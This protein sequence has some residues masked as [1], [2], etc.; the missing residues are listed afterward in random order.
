MTAPHACWTRSSRSPDRSP[1]RS[2]GHENQADPIQTE[3]P[4]RARIENREAEGEG[5]E[6]GHSSSSIGYSTTDAR[7]ASLA[8]SDP[9][10]TIV[11][12]PPA[13]GGSRALVEPCSGRAIGARLTE[14]TADSVDGR[15]SF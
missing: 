8:E 2:A 7:C 3:T 5:D 11:F 15:H 9:D 14:Q 13:F 10:A 6:L 12:P 4:Q 1:P